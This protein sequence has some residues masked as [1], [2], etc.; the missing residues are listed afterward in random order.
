MLKALYDYGVQNGL[1]NVPGFAEKAIYAYIVLSKN[2]D[3]IR[4]ES[5]QNEKH[6][7]PDIGL[8]EIAVIPPAFR[9]LHPGGIPFFPPFLGK[10]PGQMQPAC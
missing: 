1:V 4:I 5:C 7:C 3:F 6:K 10:R 9:R 8:I 2:G